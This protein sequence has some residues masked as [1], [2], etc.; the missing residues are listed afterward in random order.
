[1]ARK[2]PYLPTT[3]LRSWRRATRKHQP[4]PRNHTRSTDEAPSRNNPR[5]SSSPS[6]PGSARG[7]P[8]VG[9]KEQGSKARGPPAARAKATT[10]VPHPLR[11]PPRHALCIGL[12]VGRVGP[13][14][15]SRPGG[16][17][18]PSDPLSRREEIWR[19][20]GGL[21]W[22]DS[23]KTRAGR[24]ARPSRARLAR[25]LVLGQPL[26]APRWLAVPCRGGR[27][28]SFFRP[29]LGPSWGLETPGGPKEGG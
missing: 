1:M 13:V 6:R 27:S 10:R 8:L 15:R 5:T 11:K 17:F 19:R 23:L 20:L 25:S 2:N 21:P 18:S 28:D 22:V 4:T 7:N 26:M 14:G 29:H 3:V 24:R 16:P 12:A 9:S